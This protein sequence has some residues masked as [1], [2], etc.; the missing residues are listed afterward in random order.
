ME[1][2]RGNRRNEN[3][4]SA[5]E[6]KDAGMLF[7]FSSMVSNHVHRVCED[8]EKLKFNEIKWWRKKK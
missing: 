4:D 3:V 2:E 1:I 6:N 8:K 7:L 5:K